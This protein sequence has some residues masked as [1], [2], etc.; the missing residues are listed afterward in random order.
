MVIKMNCKECEHYK[1]KTCIW[2]YDYLNTD[3]AYDCCDFIH[4]KNC[5]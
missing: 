5:P 1:N 3:Y 4:K 2:N